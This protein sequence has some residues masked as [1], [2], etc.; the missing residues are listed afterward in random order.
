MAGNAC[1]R[2]ICLD[3]VKPPYKPATITQLKKNTATRTCQIGSAIISDQN[4]PATRKPLYSPWLAAIFLVAVNM[5]SG[6]APLNTFLPTVSHANISI[7]QMNR[8]SK[9]TRATKT[10]AIKLIYFLINDV[11]T[12]INRCCIVKKR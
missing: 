3:T 12:P 9:A 7:Q 4:K 1:L 6:M 10:Q 11:S 8:C 2:M 5:A